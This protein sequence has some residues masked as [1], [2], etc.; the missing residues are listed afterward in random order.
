ME[1]GYVILLTLIA[2]ILAIEATLW[3]RYF[4][5]TLQPLSDS[6]DAASM[7]TT[8]GVSCQA[9]QSNMMNQEPMM[10]A[11]SKGT[12]F[13]DR[14]LPFK[15]A[16]KTKPT[17]LFHEKP[18]VNVCNLAS[19]IKILSKQRLTRDPNGGLLFHEKIVIVG[20][21]KRWRASDSG[22]IKLVPE[23]VK[24]MEKL[25]RS[26]S[27]YRNENRHSVGLGHNRI[28]I[29]R[30]TRLLQCFSHL[31]T[32][33]T[34]TEIMHYSSDRQD[35]KNKKRGVVGNC[36][37]FHGLQDLLTFEMH[38]ELTEGRK[39]AYSI[40]ETIV[41]HLTDSFQFPDRQVPLL[42]GQR[43]PSPAA[44]NPISF[45]EKVFTGKDVFRIVRFINVAP[46]TAIPRPGKPSAACSLT[47]SREYCEAV[48]EATTQSS[49]SEDSETVSQSPANITP[50]E[51][52]ASPPGSQSDPVEVDMR[53]AANN[54][55]G[56]FRII[57][58]CCRMQ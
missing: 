26:A 11:Q 35:M 31:E 32:A 36:F 25:W 16:P 15:R 58:D 34:A 1:L 5:L 43:R 45:E 24:K 10:A 51:S 14:F 44:D 48:E 7:S 9:P 40:K 38:R 13:I 47:E 46:L 28:V 12:P 57:R 8:S 17:L 19:P 56:S 55:G 20:G 52:P 3:T 41:V 4:Y 21:R 33:R 39:G 2:V 42:C 53:S 27:P 54:K 37:G 30:T 22:T 50:A 18:T 49:G 23:E 6:G 29:R